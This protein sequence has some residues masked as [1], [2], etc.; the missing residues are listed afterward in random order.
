MI[1]KP[2]TCIGCPFYRHSRYITPDH[3]VPH[4]KVMFIAQNPGPDEEAGR[5]LVTRR[6]KDRVYED[7]TPQPLIGAT[8]QYFDNRFLPLSGLT[9]DEV[10]LGNAIRC[11]P[12]TSLGLK[13]DALP[14]ITS[15][16][17]LETSKA[18]IVSALKHC[19]TAHLR[20]PESVD[21]IV[22]MGRY[23]MFQLTGI[24]NEDMEYRRKQ[25]VME[26]WRGYA[27]STDSSFNSHFRTT[28][29]SVYDPLLTKHRILFTMHI[30][31]LFQGENKRF[32]NATLQDFAKLKLMREGKW[33]EPLPSYS[34]Q[35]PTEW[36]DY[37]CFDTEY[38]PETSE[39][40]RWSLTDTL[41]RNY[42]IES[43]STLNNNL[44]IKRGSTI[45]LQNAFA[46]IPYIP[47][48]MHIDFS[49]LKLEDMMLAHSVLWTGERHS[50]N[51]IASKYGTVNRW[52]HLFSSEPQQ[53]SMLDSFQPMRMW[54]GYFIPA[55]KADLLSWRLYRD[56]I[57]KLI[58]IYN[59][60][61]LTGQAVDTER[62][63]RIQSILQERLAMY[64]ARA[65]QLTG[66]VRFNLNGRKKMME[67]M[68][69]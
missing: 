23:A 14:P 59:T 68:Y 30:A 35:P 38:I 28:D 19:R 66:D 15:A 9:R 67:V 27:V 16:M 4:S 63:V 65:R 64:Q 34:T 18:D 62:L 3:I 55:F 32:F 29:T 33:P 51:F 6:Y 69:G 39:L 13:A 56:N 22:T 50:M 43:D 53:Y 11:R 45:L 24:Q 58:P 31:A 17:K 12:G 48:V 54:K 61:H 36:P 46:D 40:I 20:I 47:H 1:L 25:G 10:S 21:T 7:V 37:A 60:A 44:P 42:V 5:K 26:S 49:E 2:D 57:M 52:K 41:L 8:G